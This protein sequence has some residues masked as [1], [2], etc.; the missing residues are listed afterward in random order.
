MRDETRA[1]R[2]FEA[3]LAHHQAGRHAQA[4][5]AYRRSLAAWPGRAS[6][7]S[8]LGAALIQLGEP[9]AALQALDA[10]LAAAPARADAHGHR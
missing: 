9:A 2:E 4:V 3:G 6:T 7:L 5:A 10:A 8:N 1:R